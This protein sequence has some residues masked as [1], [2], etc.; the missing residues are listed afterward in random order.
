[1]AHENTVSSAIGCGAWQEHLYLNQP[2]HERVLTKR[3]VLY[4]GFKCN[5]RCQFCYYLKSIE[6]GTAKN[7]SF[8]WLR[9]KIT[10]AR[11]LGKEDID[12]TGGEATMHADFAKLLAHA[13]AEGFKTINVI[14][15]GWRIADRKVF[16]TFVAAG[17]NEVLFSLH[18]HHAENHDRLT[19]RKGSFDRIVAAIHHAHDLGIRVRINHVVN[20][21]NMADLEKYLSYCTS[22]GPH[23][24][25]LILF[26]PTE[27]TVKYEGH[28]K[29]QMSS[30]EEA[31][32]AVSRALD[33]YASRFPVINVRFLPFCYAKGQEAHI[34]TYWQEIYEKQEW[35]PLL[36]WA[37]RK[38]W[39]FAL[40]ASALGFLLSWIA[41]GPTRY[42][43]KNFYARLAEW[44]QL[45]RT[46]YLF[47]QK[48]GCKE[49]SLRKICPGLP[50][51]FH[52]LNPDARVFP[53]S[54]N[55]FPLIV[56]PVFFG[57]R[58]PEKFEAIKSAV[59]RAGK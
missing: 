16:E 28:S 47:H 19:Q 29:M 12:F 49:C 15:N 55:E 36:H 11:R 27:E 22:L 7:S 3:F 5:L 39:A 52:R 56:N 33:L 57:Y 41:P 24:V 9:D 42:G 1:M 38:N 18:S 50:R 20:P 51:D 45:T 25:N 2:E 10:Q 46:K 34:R 54:E 14:T 32:A 53:Y 43:K 37:F 30:Y 21:L 6:D 48:A 17:L 59:V 31:G 23:S 26:N 13:R 8:E 4:T 35:D 58:Y 44:F 40:G